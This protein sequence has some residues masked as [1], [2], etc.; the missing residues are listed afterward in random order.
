MII[1]LALFASRAAAAPNRLALLIGIN[2]Y[3]ASRLT[4]I[5]AAAPE[6]DWPNLSGAVNDT[7]AMRELLVL[8]HG[9]DG[10]DIVTL[11]DQAATRSAI[12]AA[13]NALAAK[14]SKDDVVFFFY[15][16]HGSQVKN[17]AS[18]EPDKLDESIIPADS[19]RGAADI[20]DKELR[21][22]F[23]VILDRGAHLTVIIDACHSGSAARGLLTLARPR[24][25]HPDLR[26]V[27][28]GGDYGR[29][30]E[31][32]G[33]LV[34]S[35]AHD[36]EEAR[37]IRDDQQTMHGAF[38]W[39]WMRAMRDAAP[40]ESAS[41][42]FIRAQARLRAA[43]PFQN[44]VLAGNDAQRRV[45]FLGAGVSTRTAHTAFAVERVRDGKA[46]ISGG[47]AHGI[48]IGSEL[49]IAAGHSQPPL[50][51]TALLGL[52]RCE[53][54]VPA[55]AQVKSGDLLEL[56]G[57]A[58]PPPRPSRVAI[59]RS[60]I[61]IA[62]F[63]RRAAKIA[64]EHELKWISD[65][66]VRT[67]Q[68]LLR[69][70]GARW[71]L[72]AAGGHA[73]S[74]VSDEDA[75]HA[76]A[77]LRRGT[78]LF[79]QLPA[80][81]RIAG[82]IADTPVI[83]V[84]GDAEDADYILAGRFVR[85]HVEYA[86]VRPNAAHNDRR[87][88]GLPLRTTWISDAGGDLASVL[89]N[90]AL[91]LHKIQAWSLLESPPEARWPYRLALHGERDQQLVGDG[92]SVKGRDA[93][94]LE[95]RAASPVSA[96]TSRR[97]VYIFTIDS[98]GQST[99]LFPVSGSVENHFPL[100]VGAAPSVIQLGAKLEIAPPYG[101]DTY[102]LLATD[103]PFADPWI[104]QWDGVRGPM[105]ATKTALERL[106]ALT[107]ST[108]RGAA[109]LTPATWSIERIVIESVRPTRSRKR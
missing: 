69:R 83:D 18:D 17:S 46:L 74:F 52:G 19:R 7:I 35:A 106:V 43:M 56:T 39:A 68:Y 20:R 21:R 65:P 98:Y 109:V 85:H 1:A 24:G 55:A 50:T 22:I 30:P 102:I 31:N 67:P 84:T 13:A 105:P 97:H 12:L 80:A 90:R 107:S 42:T 91:R 64:A 32:R 108:K 103:E 89:R 8:L 16:G 70:N 28:D 34:I 77:G 72:L 25:I 88:S 33:A 36:D 100:A 87:G 53:A 99:L 79:V 27:A 58:A 76:L 9:F 37:E 92:G 6:R 45:P 2:D 86:W 3:T 57:W 48:T 95:L 81:G 4:T 61:D 51:V 47:W 93:Y 101:A 71:E 54:H 96:R 29:R 82:Q 41:E 60:D 62:A 23:N 94:T 59:P 15:A 40:D 73:S 75:L 10:H 49:R 38:T 78:S 26:D 44:P 5:R 14:A 66:T 104:L 63:A 11:N